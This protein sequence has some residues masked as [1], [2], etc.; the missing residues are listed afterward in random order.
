MAIAFFYA[1]GTAL[2]GITGPLLFGKLIETGRRGQVVV[3]Y[4]LGAVLMIAGG[5]R[6]G[7]ASAWRPRR[8][9]LEDIAKPLT[10]QDAEEGEIKGE[11][12]D[13]AGEGR[14]FEIGRDATGDGDRFTRDQTETETRS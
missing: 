8:Q 5:H 12:L 1:V 3:G 11:K 6:R 4:V 13:E 10:A 2:G 7:H 14:P 9:H